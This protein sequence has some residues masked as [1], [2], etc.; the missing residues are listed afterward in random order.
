MLVCIHRNKLVIAG[1][2]RHADPERKASRIPYHSSRS[3]K[4][5]KA[6]LSIA[7]IHANTPGAISGQRIPAGSHEGMA[8]F[9]ESWC[10]DW[11]Q[12]ALVCIILGV[13]WTI[14]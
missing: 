10:A 2:A 8:N 13:L 1:S 5:W 7:G 12:H 11:R 14:L 4:E 9:L 6:S 3:P